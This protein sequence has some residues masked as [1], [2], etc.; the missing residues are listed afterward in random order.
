MVLDKIKIKTIIFDWGGV[1]CQEGEPFA[2]LDLQQTL[3]MTPDQIATQA[4]H[5][6]NGYY[7]GKYNRNE[8]WQRIIEYFGIT[9]TGKINCDTLSHAYIDSYKIYPEVFTAIKVLKNKYKI[10]LLSNLTIEM[11][12]AIR[13]KHGLEKY[14]D[15]E[16]YSCDSDVRAMK[17][18]KKPYQIILERLQS[19]GEESLFIDNSL[20]NIEVA[21]LLGF[22]T[23]LFTDVPCFLAEI[24]KLL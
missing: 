6:Y 21:K 7:V 19:T 4:R 8:F 23:I 3:T 11:R 15:V 12:D 24:N 16:V 2:S 1:C 5:I 13:L 22:Q 10:G 20:K 18:A 17:P 14:F 9:K